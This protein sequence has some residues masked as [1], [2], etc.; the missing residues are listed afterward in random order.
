MVTYLFRIDTAGENVPGYRRLCSTFPTFERIGTILSGAKS[1]LAYDVIANKDE[2]RPR[3]EQMMSKKE[4]N[5]S[6]Y[7]H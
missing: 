1:N 3:M 7:F 5:Y 6:K 2:L 4:H